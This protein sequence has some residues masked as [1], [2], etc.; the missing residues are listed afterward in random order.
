[1][2]YQVSSSYTLDQAH[3][4]FTIGQ[5]ELSIT[6]MGNPSKTDT[7]LEI[8]SF[9]TSVDAPLKDYPVIAWSASLGSMPALEKVYLSKTLKTFAPNPLPTS[10]GI[11]PYS[12]QHP[13]EV[14]ALDY[15]ASGFLSWDKE[16]WGISSSIHGA[17]VLPQ[18]DTSFSPNAFA[19]PLEDPA[20]LI[21][22]S[23]CPFFPGGHHPFRPQHPRWD[24]FDGGPRRG[25]S[26]VSDVI[27]RFGKPFFVRLRDA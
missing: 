15:D 12:V 25:P 17:L 26:E 23:K 9:I 10:I 19:L 20:G 27:Q 6:Q 24:H 1:M 16:L 21:P 13:G 8:P 4:S 18:G 5:E 22:G 7:E 2:T 14:G 11:L 3:Y